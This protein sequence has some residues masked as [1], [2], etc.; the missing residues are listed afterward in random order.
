MTGYCADCGNQ[1]C[2]C[3]RSPSTVPGGRRPKWAEAVRHFVGDEVFDEKYEYPEDG[4]ADVTLDLIEEA[5]NN[6]L[7]NTFGHE[8]IDDMCM[9]PEHRYCTYC[10]RRESML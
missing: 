10:M 2:I 5:V 4:S 6:I 3:H 1:I 8:V 9:I 7:C